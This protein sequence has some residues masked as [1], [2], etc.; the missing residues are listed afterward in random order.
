MK[1]TR[2]GQS[3]SVCSPLS[4]PLLSTHRRPPAMQVIFTDAGAGVEAAVRAV[5]PL[6]SHEL[7]LYHTSMNIRKHCS[8]GPGITIDKLL[9]HFKLAAYALTGEV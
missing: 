8:L 1:Y 5:M 6:T 3:I 9:K 4:A 7:S 2:H